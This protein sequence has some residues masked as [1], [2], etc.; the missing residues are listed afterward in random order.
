MFDKMVKTIQ[1]FSDKDI[2]DDF[3]DLFLERK[4]FPMTGIGISSV[5]NKTCSFMDDDKCYLEIGTHRG[6]TLVSAAYKNL[7]KSFYGVDNFQGHTSAKEI[8]PFDSVKA[9]LDYSISE[10]GHADVKYFHDDYINFLENRKDIEGK[11]VEIY[12]YDGDHKDINQYRGL[13]MAVP[14]LSDKS[15]VFVDDSANNDKGAVWGS[16]DKMLNEDSRFFFIREFLPEKDREEGVDRSIDGKDRGIGTGLH[17]N[18]WCGMVAL[19][20]VNE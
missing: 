9:G 12:L 20:F 14:V 4:I 7:N 6:S 13:K 8:R 10:V 17:G 3:R 19:G 18:Y 5:L 11:K 1:D 15:I 2:L 16:I